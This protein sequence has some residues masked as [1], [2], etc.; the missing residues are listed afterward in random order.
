MCELLWTLFWVAMLFI[1]LNLFISA[2]LLIFFWLQCWW[3]ES[4]HH[5]PA[6]WYDQDE[7]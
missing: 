1:G 7:Y 6:K 4:S 3:E 5:P 2:C